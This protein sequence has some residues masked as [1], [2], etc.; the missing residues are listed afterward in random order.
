VAGRLADTLRQS[1]QPDGS[2]MLKNRFRWMTTTA[3]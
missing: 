2:I 1:V 3:A